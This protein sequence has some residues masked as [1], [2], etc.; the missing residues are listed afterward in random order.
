MDARLHCGRESPL[1]EEI[2]YNSSADLKRFQGFPHAS[3][4]GCATEL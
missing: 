2:A 3:V 4:R 1:S